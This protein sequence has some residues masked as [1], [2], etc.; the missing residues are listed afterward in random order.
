MLQGIRQL[1]L[2]QMSQEVTSSRACEKLSVTRPAGIPSRAD[3]LS[4]ATFRVTGLPGFPFSGP[5]VPWMGCGAAFD[6]RG[7]GSLSSSVSVWAVAPSPLSCPAMQGQ[8]TGVGVVLG[9]GEWNIPLH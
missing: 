2:V 9:T 7:L 3:V 4:V 8:R 6:T 1:L 5:G